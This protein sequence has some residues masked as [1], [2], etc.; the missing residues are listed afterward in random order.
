MFQNCLSEIPQSVYD[1]VIRNTLNLLRMMKAGKIML[2]IDRAGY[3]HVMNLI[4]RISSLA[5]THSSRQ[6]YSL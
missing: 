6:S 4:S 2:V 5:V 3:Q 1:V